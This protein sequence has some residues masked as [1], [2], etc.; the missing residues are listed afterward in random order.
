MDRSRGVPE[1][2][3][4]LLDGHVAANHPQLTEE[5]ISR[6]SGKP[7]SGCAQRTSAACL[8][9][10]FTAGIL[11]AKR[12]SPTGGICPDCTLL[13]RPI[14]DESTSGGGTMPSASAEELAAA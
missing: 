9:G 5:S 12:D 13:V 14:F 10:T 3:I 11:S 4:G 2:A 1:I 8:H 6:L 7:S